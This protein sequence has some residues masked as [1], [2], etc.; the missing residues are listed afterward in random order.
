MHS[1]CTGLYPNPTP[2]NSQATP[3]STP[4]H[5]IPPPPHTTPLAT[6]TNTSFHSTSPQSSPLTPLYLVPSPFHTTPLPTNTPFHSTAPQPPS[7]YTPPCL[8]PPP[9]TPLHLTSSHLHRIPT[10]LA[11]ITN[12]PLHSTPP[13][14]TPPPPPPYTTPLPTNPPPTPPHLT[15]PSTPLHLTQT[16][17]LIFTSLCITQ[18]N[19]RAFE[20]LSTNY[21]YKKMNSLM[22]LDFAKTKW[23]KICLGRMT[24]NVILTETKCNFS[25]KYVCPFLCYM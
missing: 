22:Y 19:D 23:I 9:P 1:F 11:T 6:I 13:C 18:F 24:Y 20:P 3:H 16:H 5:L 21:M 7:K 14:L 2:L 17:S 25:Y 10:P 15:Q 8:T 12:T 4:P